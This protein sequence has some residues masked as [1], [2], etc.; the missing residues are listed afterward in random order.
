ME[1]TPHQKNRQKVFKRTSYKI[2]TKIELLDLYHN[3]KDQFKKTLSQRKI[4]PTTFIQWL[5]TEEKLRAKAKSAD[6]TTVRRYR[7]SPLRLV[8]DGLY[9][10]F[11]ETRAAEPHRR[12][13]DE[14]LLIHANQILDKLVESGVVRPKLLSDR[15][16]PYS[17]FQN[18]HKNK[19]DVSAKFAAGERVIAVELDPPPDDDAA[20]FF[21]GVRTLRNAGADWITIA[22]CPVGRPRADSSL[23]ACK[24]KRDFGMEPLPHIA[25]R[26]RNLNATKA[27][28]LGLAIEGIHHIL[29]VTGDPVPT[30]KRDEV[31]SVFNFNSRKLARY[32]QSLNETLQTPFQMFGALNV[33][34]RNFDRQLEFALEKETCGI[35]GFLTQPVLSPEA[36]DNLRKARTVL[37]GK[38]LGGIFP[39]VSYRNACFLNNE[40]AG[41][42]VSEDIIHR[43]EGL[44]REE[45]ESLAVE[46]SIDTAREIADFTD[47][48]Y[49]MTP[50][51]RV[52]LVEKILSLL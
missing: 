8:D 12:L 23:L 27:L 44:N 49:L 38:I 41:M 46:I 15:L 30:E 33:N 9:R 25:C 20:Y 3:N 14:D 42:R 32:I 47:G 11:L 10:W 22:D 50:F 1:G 16:G 29:I 6:I 36:M 26:D 24:V 19:Q 39:V 4:N 17:D 21:N 34:A 31:K 28:L 5:R 35:T 7:D 40:I 43:Y 37:H 51:K 18:E 52:S 13:T 48:L 2:G 45:A